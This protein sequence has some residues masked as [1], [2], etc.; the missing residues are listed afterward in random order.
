MDNISEPHPNARRGPPTPGR[1]ERLGKGRH[2]D[3]TRPQPAHRNANRQSQAPAY[4]GSSAYGTAEPQAGGAVLEMP[5]GQSDLERGLEHIRTMDPGFDT[6]RV[7]DHA[8]RVYFVV[9]QAVG[10]LELAGV[11]EYLT[12]EMA[13]VLQ[14][15]CDR[16][17]SAR[18]TNRVEQLDLRRVGP[19]REAGQP[20][21]APRPAGGR[22]C[23]DPVACVAGHNGYGRPPAVASSTSCSATSRS[24]TFSSLER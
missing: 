22:Q 6:T 20:Q 19:Q 13:A 3:R 18:R 11:R 21:L 14:A 7:V 12:P 10:L 17:R 1:H 8:R 23:R 16:L 2:D 9:Q 24:F 15:Q 4:A 5:A